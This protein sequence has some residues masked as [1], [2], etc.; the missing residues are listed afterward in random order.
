MGATG[1]FTAGSLVIQYEDDKNQVVAGGIHNSFTVALGGATVSVNSSPGL[2]SDLTETPVA[3]PTDSGGTD[4]T[5]AGPEIAPAGLGE[6]ATPP[7]AL[8]SSTPRGRAAALPF[9]R[10]LNSFGLAWGLVLGAIIVA[11]SL[12]FGLRRLTDDVFA[13]APA[14]AACPLEEPQ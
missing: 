5:V 11:M 4:S 10:T 12:A 1:S 9:R 2:N 8:A 7:S 3:G 13:T 6:I 14:A